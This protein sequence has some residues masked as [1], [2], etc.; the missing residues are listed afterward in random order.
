M[1]SISTAS[2]RGAP[3]ALAAGCA[4]DGRQLDLAGP[5]QHQ[6]QAAANHVAQRAVGLLPIPGLR[7]TGATASSGCWWDAPNELAQKRNLLAGD[8]PARGSAT[9]PAITAACQ[10]FKS[11]RKGFVAGFFSTHLPPHRRRFASPDCPP[12]AATAPGAP[13]ASAPASS[14]VGHHLKRP[15]DKRFVASQNPWPSYCKIRMAVPRRLRKM[16]RQPENGSAFSFSR[17]SCAIAID[18]L[19]VLRCTAKPQ[20]CAVH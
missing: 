10:K 6:Q 20:I 5:L 16:N 18:A 11:E 15:L 2:G 1:V 14:P 17:H 8:R 13:A 4:G 19:A 3:P 9:F 12:P 7:I